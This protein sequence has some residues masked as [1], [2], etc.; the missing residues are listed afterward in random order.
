M[1]SIV[2]L[3]R[4]IINEMK[5][6]V[7]FASGS[8]SNAENIVEYFWRRPSLSIQF[9]VYTNNEKAGV[10]NRCRKLHIPCIL[11]DKD[12]FNDPSFLEMI[13]EPDLII[14]AGFLWLIPPYFVNRFTDKIINIHPSLLPLYGGKGMYGDKVHQSV[15]KNKDPQTGITI[16]IVNEKYDEGKILLQA[17]CDVI[18]GDDIDSLSKKVHKLEH[19]YFPV[20]IEQL[21]ND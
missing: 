7:I 16:H 11:I 19:T 9:E 3:L 4:Q 8:G 12:Q 21:I 10:V 2:L 20:L 1:S 18:E 6:I 13:G 5:R 17:R 14:L 15:L